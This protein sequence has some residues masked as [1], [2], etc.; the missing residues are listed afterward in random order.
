MEKH[1]QDGDHDH[2]Q[3][4]QGFQRSSKPNPS[5]NQLSDGVV[6]SK[7]ELGPSSL[8][9]AAASMLEVG[10]ESHYTVRTRSAR[11][12]SHRFPSTKDRSH[13]AT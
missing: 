7:T 8:P 10:V 12:A 1:L 11:G 5:E 2:D 6:E 3:Y 4:L 13:S 9:L